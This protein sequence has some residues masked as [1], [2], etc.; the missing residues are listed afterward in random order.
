MNDTSAIQA[1]FF[2]LG[3]EPEIANIYLALHAYGDQTISEVSRRSG[4]ERTRIYRLMD[5]LRESGLVEIDTQYKR[6]ILRAAPITNLQILISKKEQEVRDLQTELQDLHRSLNHAELHSA[7]TSVRFY[8]GSEGI[9]QMVW[10]QTKSHSENLA[11]LYENMQI[12]TKL[13]FFERWARTC[14]ER[15]LTFRGIISDNFIKTQQEWYGEHSN[16]RLESWRSRYIPDSIFAI[17]H[18]TVIYDDIVAYYNWKGGEVF[19]IE[20]RNQQ[21]ADTQRFFFETLWSQ[22]KDVDDLKGLQ[23]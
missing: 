17:N 18:S 8:Q 1:Y 13:A 19:G 5:T 23:S 22:G 21:I 14:N 11:I 16:E 7:T 10:N 15:G 3:L 6:Q 20:I 12:R 4:V 2:K 9:K